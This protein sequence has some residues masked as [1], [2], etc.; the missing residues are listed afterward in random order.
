MN[1]EQRLR[2]RKAT[3]ADALR[4]G[5]LSIDA[6]LSDDDEPTTT[7]EPMDDDHT[8]IVIVDQAD[9]IA[10]AA[11]FGPEGHSDRVWNLY[12]L[13]VDAGGR[14]TGAGSQLVQWVETNL[15]D[16]GEAD[17]KLLL[18]ETSSVESFEPTRAFYRGLGYT[19]EARIREYYGQGDDKIVYWKLLH[20]PLR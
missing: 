17:A 2:I 6:G 15:R 13:A 14:G 10:G 12:F 8:W 1:T 4:I 11:Y 5:Q 3:Q 9:A 19:E 20:P 18:I 7:L 16:R